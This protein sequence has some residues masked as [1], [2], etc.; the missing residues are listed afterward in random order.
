MIFADGN[1]LGEMYPGAQINE[2]YA[3]SR[4]DLLNPDASGRMFEP[5]IKNARYRTFSIRQ[6]EKNIRQPPERAARSP[7]TNSPLFA[8]RQRYFHLQATPKD[9]KRKTK[10]AKRHIFERKKKEFA[11]SKVHWV[12][13]REE[14]PFYAS[15]SPGT[16]FLTHLSFDMPQPQLSHAPELLPDQGVVYRSP[17]LQ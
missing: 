8:V 16:H 3:L 1:C 5:R 4:L 9:F 2:M 13:K 15:R 11:G 14:T 10:H 12:Q 7:E 6:R 17:R